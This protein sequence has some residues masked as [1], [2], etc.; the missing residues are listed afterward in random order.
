VEYP[1][2]Q[3]E[4]L[5]RYCSKLTALNEGNVTFFHLEGLRLPSGCVPQT[6]DALLCPVDRESYP[7]RLYFSAQ[8]VSPYTRN[9]N[10]SNARIGEKNW[11]AFS[12]KVTLVSPTLVQLLLAHL[13]G[14]T[15][16]K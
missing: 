8:I 3:L 7:S 10:V 9:W 13:E 16:E 11:F 14:F 15:R 5:K 1:R 6:C 12:W 2:E 4:D